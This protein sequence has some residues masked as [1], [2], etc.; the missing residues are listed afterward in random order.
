MRGVGVFL[1]PTQ[2]ACAWRAATTV[3]VCIAGQTCTFG[4]SALEISYVV[5]VNLRTFV[6]RLLLH[7][8]WATTTRLSVSVSLF[9]LP[10]SLSLA[11]THTHTH[12]H[13]LSLYFGVVHA[14]ARVHT[15]P[16]PCV[17]VH[18]GP[19]PCARVLALVPVPVPARCSSHRQLATSSVVRR[20]GTRRGL[21]GGRRRCGWG[22]GRGTPRWRTPSHQ[23]PAGP[24]HTARRHARH[25]RHAQTQEPRQGSNGNAS[26]VASDIAPASSPSSLP[27]PPFYP[28]KHTHTVPRARATRKGHSVVPRCTPNAWGRRRRHT[29]VPQ[30]HGRTPPRVQ[31]ALV[32]WWAVGRMSTQTHVVHVA[33]DDALVLGRGLRHARKATLEHVVAVQKRL[34]HRRLEPHL[35]LQGA[36]GD[37]EQRQTGT[38]PTG[39]SASG[40]VRPTARCCG[41][42]PRCARTVHKSCTAS[43]GRPSRGPRPEFKC[44]ELSAAVCVCVCVCVCACCV[45]CVCVCVCPPLIH[46]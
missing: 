28:P 4:H 38:K 39:W 3:R 6:F 13:S 15:G 44:A 11:H 2:T 34:L 19:C 31:R 24:V 9:C 23:S 35:V 10:L 7:R 1:G 32:L 37:R 36:R 5:I 45:V 21:P 33:D 26:G 41:R 8:L 17:R 43:R 14:A 16:C 22:R 18:K 29:G 25:A 46:T 20:G 12:T 42:G 27:L 40:L 30:Q